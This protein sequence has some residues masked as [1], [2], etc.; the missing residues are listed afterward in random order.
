M[1]KK[2][3]SALIAGG[4][5]VTYLGGVY[6]SGLKINEYLLKTSDYSRRLASELFV[7]P[8]E[9][10]VRYLKKDSGFF[11]SHAAFEIS[12]RGERKVLPIVIHNGFFSS[13][14]NIDTQAIK[15]TVI[16]ANIGNFDKDS[17]NTE[18]LVDVSMI[19]GECKLKLHTDAK[20]LDEK[21]EPFSFDTVFNFSSDN[22]VKTELNLQNY[23]SMTSGYIGKLSYES[24]ARGFLKFEGFDYLKLKVND[25]SF[26]LVKTGNFNLELDSLKTADE[27]IFDLNVKTSGD[28]LC[29]VIK[30]FDIDLTAS[31]FDIDKVA[32]A[33]TQM[34]SSGTDYRS[35]FL[36]DL[37]N[38]SITK[39]NLT[40]GRLASQYLGDNVLSELKL[41]GTG[42][43]AFAD[44]KLI[45]SVTGSLDVTADDCQKALETSFFV[46]DDSSCHLKIE[47]N[48]HRV[49]ING[50]DL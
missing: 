40:P 2:L 36:E 6:F 26:G 5:A 46:K 22:R 47:V 43:F 35:A 14:I 30:D 10:S 16:K 25:L 21:K 38:I 3:I 44:N 49:L 29:D 7:N 41:M 33:Y 8:D 28:N 1:K 24:L 39:L 32:K 9:L 15:Q 20:Y 19:F 42:E 48:D 18:A 11:V 34:A 23:Y 31:S 45:P 37:K 50:Q 27:K 17:V 4:V 13:K 12:F